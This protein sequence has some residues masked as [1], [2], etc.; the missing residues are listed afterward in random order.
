LWAIGVD[1]HFFQRFRGPAWRTQL[2]RFA[3]LDAI[4]R[5]RR[6]QHIV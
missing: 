5:Q 3:V 4:A 2:A 6:L 1:R